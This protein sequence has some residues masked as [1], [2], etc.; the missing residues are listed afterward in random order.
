M[1]G[2]PDPTGFAHHLDA[3]LD[4]PTAAGRTLLQTLGALAERA[5]V[6]EPHSQGQRTQRLEVVVG[7]VL[8]AVTPVDDVTELA[9]LGQR[10]QVDEGSTL[11]VD[12]P[13]LTNVAEQRC[14]PVEVVDLLGTMPHPEA[15]AVAIMEVGRQ[16]CVTHEAAQHHLPLLVTEP[17]CF[18]DEHPV[19]GDELTSLTPSAGSTDLVV[20]RRGELRTTIAAGL[21]HGELQEALGHPV[22]EPVGDRTINDLV[23]LGVVRADLDRKASG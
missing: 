3:E 13:A 8:L 20:V 14:L 16:M 17:G 4:P 23:E 11:G 9:Q 10:G 21:L 19:A 5:V 18:V 2:E 7:Q 12:R 6:H 22:V 1:V 15:H